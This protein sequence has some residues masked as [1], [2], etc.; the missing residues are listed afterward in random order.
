MIRIQ[1]LLDDLK[2]AATL[3]FVLRRPPGD[4][5]GPCLR[6]AGT[7]EDLLDGI[8][9]GSVDV[10]VVDPWAGGAQPSV[11]RRIGFLDEHLGPGRVVLYLSPVTYDADALVEIGR[12]GFSSILISGV[13]DDP[14]ALRR[15]LGGAAAHVFLDK[16]AERLDG[17]LEPAAMGFLVGALAAAIAAQRVD[18]LARALLMDV[19]SLRAR[20]RTLDLPT[21]R[22]LL[23][24]GR[25][26]QVLG[27]RRLGVGSTA[28]LAYHTGYGDPGSLC[29][30]F[31]TLLG[32][33][34]S[35]VPD[36]DAE[37]LVAEGILGRIG[38]S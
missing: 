35:K 16:T 24:W 32:H 33:P 6:C 38:S 4:P 29:R 34:A 10:S 19:P 17:H 15:A 22:E 31:R 7:W 37:R 1:A 3:R 28:S 25:L 11:G 14:A 27:F 9:C 5:A 2:A 8:A 18:D 13:D 23:R 36:A 26:I 20:T 30:L 12:A 21:P